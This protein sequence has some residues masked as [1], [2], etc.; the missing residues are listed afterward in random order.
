MR[1]RNPEIGNSAINSEIRLASL[2]ALG[3]VVNAARAAIENEPL[4]LGQTP[5]EKTH[6]KILKAGNSTAGPAQPTSRNSPAD[7]TDT[8]QE[9]TVAPTAI[10]STESILDYHFPRI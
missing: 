4:N 6:V 1:T 7:S 8:E 9:A 3:N 2:R 10:N 5:A